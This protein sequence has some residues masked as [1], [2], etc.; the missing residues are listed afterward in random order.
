TGLCG[1]GLVDFLDREFGRGLSVSFMANQVP[2]FDNRIELHPNIKDKWGRPVA[3]IVKGWHPHDVYLMRHL[4]EQCG[5]VLPYG[6]DP[7]GRNYPVQG[8]GAIFMA[9]NALARMANHILGGARFGTDR[10]DSVLDRN[11]RAWDFENLYVTDGA[12]MPTSGSCNPT[13]TIQ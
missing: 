4:A 12:F 9:E 13:L 11:C 2:Q 5:K 8:E 7:V 1:Q 10:N 3:Y 6:G